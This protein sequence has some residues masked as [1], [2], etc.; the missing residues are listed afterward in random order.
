MP[1]G[2][3]RQNSGGARQGAGRPLGSA[4]YRTREMANKIADDGQIG[5][6]SVM[7]EC[8]RRRGRDFERSGEADL[9][10]MRDASVLAREAAPYLHPKLASRPEKGEDTER[11]EA[12]LRKLFEL[13]APLEQSTLEYT[14][15]GARPA[16]NGRDIPE[17]VP[18]LLE[19]KKT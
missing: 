17:S 18:N 14:H 15:K 2:G 11:H 7:I 10:A 13:Q 19:T 3:R 1:H 9:E 6:L 5:P 8:M 16:H 4:T 12:W